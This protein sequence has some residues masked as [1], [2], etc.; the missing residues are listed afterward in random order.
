MEQATAVDPPIVQPVVSERPIGAVPEESEHIIS[1][2]RRHIFMLSNFNNP[3]PRVFLSII[4]NNSFF[5]L[6]LI[7]LDNK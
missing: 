3:G 5:L 6:V 2:E 7:S 1:G 4:L